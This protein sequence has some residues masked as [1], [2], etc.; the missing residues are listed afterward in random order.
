MKTLKECRSLLKGKVTIEEIEKIMEASK[1]KQIIFNDYLADAEDYDVD[2]LLC[3]GDLTIDGN[4]DPYDSEI[5][6]LIVTGNLTVNGLFEFYDDPDTMVFVGGN[7][8]VENL[9]VD[10]L[11]EVCGD[12]TV[13]N[14]M[15]TYDEG[16][17]DVHGTVTANFFL[18]GMT[19]FKY[20]KRKFGKAYMYEH[21][22]TPKDKDL[23][24]IN[25]REMYFLMK[26]E[27]FTDPADMEEA[28]SI[29]EADWKAYPF[30]DYVAFQEIVGLLRDG[31][32]IYREDK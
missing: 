1:Q 15:T 2:T 18:P 17:V 23:P 31:E 26:D 22:V 4:F 11:L 27:A 10:G 30:F 32:S 7:L 8:T 21:K 29:E 24:L 14:F 28:L 20:G 25:S 9:A 19:S 12:L 16:L 5:C 6:N 13:K 3:E